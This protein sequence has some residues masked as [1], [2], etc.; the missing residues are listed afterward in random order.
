MEK[1]YDPKY[2][3]RPINRAIEKYI[4]NVLA[5]SMLKDEIIPNEEVVLVLNQDNNVCVKA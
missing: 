5:E 2:G 1:G 4:E 3:A